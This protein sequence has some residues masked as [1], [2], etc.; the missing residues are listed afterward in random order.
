MATL[1]YERTMAFSAKAFRPFVILTLA[2]FSGSKPAFQFGG[3]E[4]KTCV[5]AGPF[6]LF[7]FCREYV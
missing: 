5:F 2:I 1:C 6:C 3:L 7:G 4:N